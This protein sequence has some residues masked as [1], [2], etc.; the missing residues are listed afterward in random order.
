V[1]F[2][3]TD[4]VRALIEGGTIQSSLVSSR[5]RF[6]PERAPSFAAFLSFAGP[7]TLTPG[8]LK[9]ADF[10]RGAVLLPDRKRQAAG[11]EDV[12]PGTGC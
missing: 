2:E 5:K 12:D 9:S 10:R 1:G 8:R 6:C 3:P 11:M 7:S 4:D